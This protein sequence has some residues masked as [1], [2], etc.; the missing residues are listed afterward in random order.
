[1]F[2]RRLSGS[3]LLVA[4]TLQSA[5]SFDR[6]S[7][8]DL[9]LSEDKSARGVFQ[10]YVAL[11]TSISAGV[12]GDGLTAQTQL[13]SWPA[14][15][16]AMADRPMTL[17]LIEAPGCRSPLVAPL[18]SG[19]RVSGEAAGTDAANLSCA[20]LQANVTLPPTNVALNGARANDALFTTPQNITDQGNAKIYARVLQA[21]QTQLSTAM[22][23]NPKLMSFE[24]GGNEILDARSGIAI[25][26]VTLG[27]LS[28]FK[29]AYTQ[30]LDSAEKVTKMAIVAG[31]IAD[32]RSFPAFRRGDELWANRAEFAGFNVAVSND[33]QGSENLL[34][35]PVRVPVAV[36]TGVAYAKQGMGPFTL[37]CA[38]GGATDQDYVLTPA[39]VG[40]VNDL[41]HA[42]TAHIKAEATKRGFAYFELGALYDRADIKG[43]Y[44]VVAQMTSNTPYGS[45][46]SLDGMH[47]SAAGQTVLAKAAAAALDARY[48]LGIL[49]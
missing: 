32:V 35:V 19:V 4:L 33:C 14:Q 49:Q 11:G 10:R 24:F 48:G 2:S 12:Q 17:P 31:L 20:P 9:S 43:T 22:A 5:C 21:G 46:V 7:A 8:P 1:M 29:A 26:G 40:I 34:F 18:A 16:A 3:V 37:S 44:S 45:L 42:M 38:A 41:M 30:L 27:S 23:L 39:E 25:P 15:L 47:P 6:S 28:I 36:G 13:T